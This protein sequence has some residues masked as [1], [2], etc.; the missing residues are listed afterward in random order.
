[1][2]LD[3]DFKPLLAAARDIAARHGHSPSGLE[4]F[5]L[6]FAE[7][8]VGITYFSVRAIR[9]DRLSQALLARLAATRPVPGYR[10]SAAG[11]LQLA[12]AIKRFGFRMPILRL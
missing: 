1:M 7:T 2:R 6:A 3:A 9:I 10:G 8:S 4:H 12:A 5:L 11:E